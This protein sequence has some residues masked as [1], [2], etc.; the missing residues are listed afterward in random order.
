[1]PDDEMVEVSRSL[2]KY[3][4]NYDIYMKPPSGRGFVLYKPKGV[5]IEAIR[6]K[7]KRHPKNLYITLPDKMKE[8]ASFQRRYNSELRKKIKNEPAEARRILNKAMELSFSEPRTQVL[9]NMRETIDIIVLEYLEDP[10]VV[11]RLIEVSTKD[12]STSI[13]SV[14]VMLYCLGY[15][16]FCKFSMEEI[17]VFGLAGLL[18]DVGK[19]EVPNEILKSSEE[20]NVRET[21]ILRRHVENGYRILS[22]CEFDP[23]VLMGALEHHELIDGSGYPDEK[24]G[25]EISPLSRV[26]ALINRFENLTGQSPG[27]ESL[28]PIE[29]LAFMMGEVESGKY[30]KEMFKQM[31][32]SV[33]GMQ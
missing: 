32:H 31:A 2:G 5:P 25:D 9:Q 22:E 7:E 1:M 29:A 18:H 12:Y 23:V 16:H 14:N 28:K 17:K 26:L 19:V 24:K 30:D 10:A 4:K 13:H 15:G 11:S 27:K 8:I 33:V 21:K 20:L 6:I 3:Y